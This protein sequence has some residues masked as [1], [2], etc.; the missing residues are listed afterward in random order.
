MNIQKWNITAFFQLLQGIDVLV[1]H[2]FT[3]T[4][5]KLRSDKPIKDQT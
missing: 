2:S 1:I 5:G 4:R 3:E